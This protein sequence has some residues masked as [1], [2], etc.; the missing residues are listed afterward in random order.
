MFA[1]LSKFM[2]RKLVMFGVVS[3]VLLA[4]LA[5]IVPLTSPY[6]PS[7]LDIMARLQPPSAAHWFG[8]D[9]F[10]RDIFTRVLTGGRYSLTIGALVVVVALVAGVLMGLCAGFFKRMDAPI[11]R[12]VDA[13][14][15]FPD[16]LLAIALVAILGSSLINVV[17]ALAI[18][19]TP[20][21]ARIV[22]ASTLVVRELLFVEAA[23]ALGVSTLR[24]VFFHVL[25]NILSP[26]LVQGTFIF[27]YA[28]LAEA[29]LSFLGV[30]VPPELPTWGT[31]I[32]SGQAYAEQAIWLVVFPGIAIVLS[33]LSLQM[34]GDGLR[35]MLDPR[36]RKSL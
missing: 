19:Y 27:A 26:I 2:R 4:V 23:R 5:V 17:L 35:D 21:V 36:L 14:M 32:S 28:I 8:T 33:A 11:M 31:M 30:G 25:G 1:F 3:L 10:G 18:V 34:V 20:R 22:R 13:M 24:I 29:G 12:V 16:I 15:S 6:D 9:E 7:A